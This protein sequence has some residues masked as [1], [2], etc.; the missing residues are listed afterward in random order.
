MFLEEFIVIISIIHS[1][2]AYGKN[3]NDKTSKT[4]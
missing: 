4:S 2:H 1:K 3:K